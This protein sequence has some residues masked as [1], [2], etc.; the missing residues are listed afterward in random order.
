MKRVL[1]ITCTLLL[2]MSSLNAQDQNA[3]WA[4]FGRFDSANL[5]VKQL[6]AGDRQVVFMGNS[7]TEGWY[8]QDKDFFTQ[9][10]YINR[11]ISGQTTSQMLIRF[12]KDVI[13][14]A[15][16]VVVILAGTNDIAGNT[17]FISLDNILGNLVS[18]CELAK[19]HHISPVLCSVLPAFD[20]PW[21]PGKQPNI[22]IPQLNTLIKEY[23]LK[24]HIAYVDYFSAMTDGNNGL[25]KRISGDG[26]HPNA[27]GNKIME[28]T[29]KPVIDRTLKQ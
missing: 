7:I 9:N 11:G 8:R 27:D 3:D 25:P 21:R 28:Q 4:N 1:L 17:G 20:Y 12:R 26:V 14:L 24:N 10:K 18:M 16:K 15:P 22:K 29:L 23:A 2:T 19:A 13:E 6:P 5:A